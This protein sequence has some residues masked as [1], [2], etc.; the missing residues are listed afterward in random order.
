[1]MAEDRLFALTDQVEQLLARQTAF[2]AVFVHAVAPVMLQVIPTMALDL[3][4][5]MRTGLTVNAPPGTERLQL[6]AEEHIQSLAD[7]LERQ[8]RAPTGAAASR[9]D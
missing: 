6:L 9:S 5:G 8:L 2:E 3:V 4:A 1:M 7:R